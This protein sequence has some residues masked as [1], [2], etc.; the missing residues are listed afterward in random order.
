MFGLND[1]FSSKSEVTTATNQSLMLKKLYLKPGEE[2]LCA[3]SPKTEPVIVTCFY[4]ESYKT[5]F[6]LSSREEETIALECK[7]GDK[8]MFLPVKNVQK[9]TIEIL[10]FSLA[11][12]SKPNSQA[13]VI[14]AVLD[15]EKLEDHLLELCRDSE[16]EWDYT[17]KLIANIPGVDCGHAAIN[18]FVEKHPGKAI[19]ELCGIKS[20]TLQQLADIEP[21]LERKI[22]VAQARAQ[23]KAKLVAGDE[24]A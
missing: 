23:L 12:L 2:V 20:I 9:D 3:I 13:S 8:K 1:F 6:Y 22:K 24:A 17:A 19:L 5:T 7:I 14:R 18:E 15:P 10:G 11:H 4:S 21:D 16:K